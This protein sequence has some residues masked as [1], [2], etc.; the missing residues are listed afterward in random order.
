MDDGKPA[1]IDL[2]CGCGGFGLGAELAGFHTAVAV[3]VDKTLQSA[4][5]RNFPGT[6]V[7]NADLS[8]MNEESWRIV[9]N[10]VQVEGV[11][12][13]PPCQGYSRMGHSDK[14][15][16]RRS[17]LRHYFRTVNII[18]PKFF[19]M[20]NVEGL[21]DEKNVY[22]LEN[23]LKTL[24]SDYTVL[25]PTVLDASEFGAPT[26]RRRV[27]VVG[28][29]QGEISALTVEDFKPEPNLLTTVREAISDLPSPL[30]RF[31]TSN[32][33]DYSWNLLKSEN[34]LS[35]YARLMRQL[36]P[37]N[38]GWGKAVQE[39]KNGRVSGFLNTRHS[40]A[41]AAR[42]KATQPGAVDKVSK[43]KRLAWDGQCPT[44]RAGTGSDKGSH[45]AV[46][47]LHPE[48]GRVITVREAAR[49][50]GFPDWFTF[51]HTKWHSFRMIGNSVSPIVSRT[52][53]E[54]VYTALMERRVCANT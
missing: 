45:Q 37:E 12:G 35:A 29:L 48:E 21:M 53:M 44:L 19:V 4:Y 47:P 10:N 24:S 32:L 25:K 30:N 40:E 38:L 36:P 31:Q 13:G 33:N 41:V 54:T 50:Q 20:E 52:I 9:L 8:E 23:A 18:R 42:Y 16:P 28:Y 7:I 3:D 5:S 43:S 51:H 26:K 34:Q 2:F 17:L 22:E 1:I 39:L 6:R 49:L 27:I 15:D 11:I 14:N 46:R